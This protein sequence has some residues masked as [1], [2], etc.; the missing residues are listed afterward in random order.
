M[1]KNEY[2][3]HKKLHDKDYYGICA[4][5]FNLSNEVIVCL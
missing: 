5:L 1:P 2:L 4:P 3:C